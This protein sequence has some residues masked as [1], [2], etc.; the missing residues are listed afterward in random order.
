AALS[1]VMALAAPTSSP[2]APP[3]DQGVEAAKGLHRAAEV[4][5]REGRYER[6]IDAWQPAY[7]LDSRA[8]RLLINIG[9]AHARA[10]DRRAAAAAYERYLERDDDDETK[11]AIAARLAE[12]REEPDRA[13]AAPPET[14]ESSD[15]GAAE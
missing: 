10:G 12:L 11:R 1:A 4:H 8:H 13:M 15:A 9:N 2:C 7:E 14:G 3:S 6:A 5:F